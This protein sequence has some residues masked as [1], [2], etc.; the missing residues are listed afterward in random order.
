MQEGDI[1]SILTVASVPCVVCY[2]ALNRIG[3]VVDFINVLSTAKDLVRS[4]ISTKPYGFG[5]SIPGI[6][7]VSITSHEEVHLGIARVHTTGNLGGIHYREGLFHMCVS[8][9]DIGI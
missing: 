4:G 1:V 3:A 7:E 2:Y 5:E 8:K 6:D 9:R